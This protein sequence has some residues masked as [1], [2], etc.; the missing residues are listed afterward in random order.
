MFSRVFKAK[1]SPLYVRRDVLNADE[2][3]KWA[4]SVGFDKCVEPKEMHVTIVFSRTP[5]PMDV[6]KPKSI[7]LAITG[8]ARSVEPLGDEG[9][10]VMKFAA[11]TL[12]ARWQAFRDAGASWD[13]ESYTPHITLTYH[14]PPKLD[15]KKVTPYP[16]KILLGPEKFEALDLD[17]KDKIVEKGEGK[18]HPFRGNQYTGG[19]YSA[20]EAQWLRELVAKQKN[21]KLPLGVRHD[22]VLEGERLPLENMTNFMEML[23]EFQR[24]NAKSHGLKYGGREDFVLAEGK[25]FHPPESPPPI[26]LG[27]PK[28]CFSN[29]A[30]MVLDDMSGKYAYVEGF[31]QSPK[32]P[33]P[34]HH[35]WVVD[36]ETSAVIDPT[37]GWSPKNRYMGVQ[38]DTKFL[39][40]KL[41]EQGY[42]G[43]LSGEHMVN[44]IALGQDKDYAYA[45]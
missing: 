39:R 24:S 4:K 36:K 13:F 8:G 5:L 29:A 42:Y 3:I 44:P 11:P 31:V 14:N 26:K 25:E 9:A 38:F 40:K 33:M 22:A 34:I 7:D 19:A 1:V 41:F 21:T 37:L 20:K 43:L 2:I 18:G 17:W 28:Q 6:L 23:A 16:G 30:K 15:L 32:L 10:V 27:V 12:N 45:H 35:A